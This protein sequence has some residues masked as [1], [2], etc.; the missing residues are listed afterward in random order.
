MIRLARIGSL[1]PCRTVIVVIA[2]VAIGAGCAPDQ[3][4]AMGSLFDSPG[5]DDEQQAQTCGAGP[6]VK[7]ID[8]SKWQGTINWDEVKNDGVEFAIMRVSDGTS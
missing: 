2:S 1:L 5:D 8:V 4:L 3:D 7:G 6:T